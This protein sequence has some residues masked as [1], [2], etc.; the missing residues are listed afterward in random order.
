[1]MAVKQPLTELTL[2]S[3][4]QSTEEW[5]L[6]LSKNSEYIFSIISAAL[7]LNIYHKFQLLHLNIIDSVTE[8]VDFITEL[9]FKI[10]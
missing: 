6:K 7:L 10:F 5:Q 3:M 2:L 4:H 1:M 9:L 8:Q